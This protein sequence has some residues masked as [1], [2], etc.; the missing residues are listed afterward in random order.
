MNH[1][2]STAAASGGSV[3]PAERAALTGSTCSIDALERV[4]DAYALGAMPEAMS[5]AHI[6]AHLSSCDYCSR[7]LRAAE[8]IRGT[9]A[10]PLRA[11]AASA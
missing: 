3:S 10:E 2:V 11:S 5:Q 6:Q 4:L 9:R 8:E 7:L 1:S